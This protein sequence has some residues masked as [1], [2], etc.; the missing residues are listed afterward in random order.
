[1]II[2]FLIRRWIPQVYLVRTLETGVVIGCFFSKQQA[3]Q[4]KNA[5]HKLW[6]QEIDFTI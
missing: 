2:K 1:M 4:I 6:V 3:F 5:G